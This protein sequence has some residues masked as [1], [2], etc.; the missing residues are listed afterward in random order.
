MKFMEASQHAKRMGQA[1]RAFATV[2]EV[3]LT[4]AK[5]EG[6]CGELERKRTELVDEVAILTARRVALFLEKK[7]LKASSLTERVKAAADLKDLLHV[8]TLQ[9]EEQKR[10]IDDLRH[11]AGLEAALVAEALEEKLNGLKLDIHAA[12][13]Q[14]AVA[15]EAARVAR[16]MIKGLG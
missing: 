4:A 3:C 9:L 7:E 1:F 2:E 11:A 8:G 6:A 14:R 15:T 12:E 13:Q 5:A 10:V 16:D